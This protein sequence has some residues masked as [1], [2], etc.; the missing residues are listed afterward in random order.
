MPTSSLKAVFHALHVQERGAAAIEFAFVAIVFAALI[1]GVSKTGLQILDHQRLNSISA[2]VA[3]LIT[4]E[5]A[6]TEAKVDSILNSAKYLGGD[7]GLG[8]EGTI[9]VSGI[10]GQADGTSKVAWQ[11]KG[12]GTLAEASRVGTASKSATLPTGFS[13]PPNQTVVSVEVMHRPQSVPATVN[14]KS[15]TTVKTS[16]LRSRK[17]ELA[18]MTPN[19]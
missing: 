14:G 12:A 19:S 8:S 17:N 15:M 2:R 11:R 13:V 16:F 7:N 18:T 4:Q 10:V 1:F 9:I 6:L 3:D 5:G